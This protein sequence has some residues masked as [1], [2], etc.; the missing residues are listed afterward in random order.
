MSRGTLDI[1][2]HLLISPTRLLLPMVQL[3]ICFDYVPMLLCI[4]LTPSKLGLG[5]FH[6]ARRYFENRV[7]FLFLQV[8][9]CFSSPG[10]LLIDY[11]IHLR[12]TGLLPAGFPHSD[13]CA[14]SVICTYTQLFAACH[15]LLRL[16]VPRHSPYALINLTFLSS[17][18][19][20]SLRHM[21]SPVSYV[22]FYTLP[23]FFLMF[24]DIV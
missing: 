22:S 8:L 20:Q 6:F 4:F 5:S 19:L 12:V 21:F 15:V 13:I 14:L 23:S 3:P 11:F 2:S 1:Y 7:F 9:R 18:I 16:S 10:S 24:L 17:I